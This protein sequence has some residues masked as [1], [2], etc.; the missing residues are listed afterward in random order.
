[1]IN[2]V[3]FVALWTTVL[4]RDLTHQDDHTNTHTYDMT[5]GFKPLTTIICKEKLYS[6]LDL[7][8]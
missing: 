4:L 1:M 6:C 3:S 2:Q 8:V 5:A 7:H